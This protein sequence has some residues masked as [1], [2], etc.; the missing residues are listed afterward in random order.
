MFTPTCQTEA[1]DVIAEVRFSDD[2]RASFG[3]VNG[4]GVPGD[5]NN[6]SLVAKR[7]GADKTFTGAIGGG[8]FIE[9]IDH[10]R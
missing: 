3:N 8:C 6:G 10:T 1:G 9:T 2:T 4:Q 5:V 7:S